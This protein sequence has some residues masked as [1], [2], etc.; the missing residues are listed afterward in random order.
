V[1]G[2]TYKVLK[3][4]RGVGGGGV[5]ITGPRDCLGGAVFPPQHTGKSSGE[6]KEITRSERAYYQKMT[7]REKRKLYHAAPIA[8]VERSP[9]IKMVTHNVKRKE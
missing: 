6:R 7:Q 8:S 9:A 5:K 1:G 4:K 3:K 2:R